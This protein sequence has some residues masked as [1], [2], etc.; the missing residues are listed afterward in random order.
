MTGPL[1]AGVSE[2]TVLCHAPRPTQSRC[3]RKKL[4][5]KAGAVIASPTS[6]CFLIASPDLP[7]LMPHSFIPELRNKVSRQNF[8]SETWSELARGKPKIRN[9]ERA[10]LT[11]Q[12]CVLCSTIKFTYLD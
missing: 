2:C 3:H 10:R 7:R 6:A 8:V 1:S 9:R 4:R 11:Y 5:S 12:M